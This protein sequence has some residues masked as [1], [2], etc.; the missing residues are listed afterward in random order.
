[1]QSDVPDHKKVVKNLWKKICVFNKLYSGMSYSVMSIGLMLRN[2]SY[3]ASR[4]RKKKFAGLC[5][6][7]L[8]KVLR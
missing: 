6:R 2:Q 8:Q 4:K 3:G 5:I 7:P 1:M